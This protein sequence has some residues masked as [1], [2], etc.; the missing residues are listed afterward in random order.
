M[1]HLSPFTE[2]S[3]ERYSSALFGLLPELLGA[4]DGCLEVKRDEK[5]AAIEFFLGLSLEMDVGVVGEGANDDGVS[6]VVA[7]DSG[8]VKGF[9]NNDDD[10]ESDNCF[11][12]LARE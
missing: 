10:D 2:P 11:S 4:G 9:N 5:S 8:G 1:G 3:T 6:I 12:F 7:A